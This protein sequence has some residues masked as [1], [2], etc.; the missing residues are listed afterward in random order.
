M[1]I[2]LAPLWMR[3]VY[4]CLVAAAIAVLASAFSAGSHR[5]LV[6]NWP[7]GTL[8]FLVL[9]A[10]LGA[11]LTWR[12]QTARL[13]YV[14]QV[15]GLTSA[16]RSVAIRATTGGPAPEDPEVLKAALRLGQ[17]YLDQHKANRR[18]YQVMT[19]IAI[20]VAVFL[21]I[22]AAVEGDAWGLVYPIIVLIVVP[23]MRSWT[24]TVAGRTKRQNKML[25]TARRGQRKKRV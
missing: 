7:L 21:L 24:E 2:L 5:P 17:V 10:V 3:A 20:T 8:A 12:S 16:Q 4:W 15:A 19:A 9:A 1:R 6:L 14:D 25:V 13:P 23:L 18:R 22:V 11:L